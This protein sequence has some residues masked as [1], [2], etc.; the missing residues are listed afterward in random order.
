MHPGLLGGAIGLLASAALAG[1][2]MPGAPRPAS[3][4][5]AATPGLDRELRR[6]LGQHGFT[7]L[8]GFTV[9]ARLGRPLDARLADLGRL[10]FFDSI[11][12]LRNDTSCASCHGPAWGFGDSQSIAIG[13]GNNGISGPDRFGA[14][15]QRRA[16][17]VIN[18]AFYP[19]QMLN[20]RFESLSG[21]SFDNSMGFRFPPPE[22][23]VAFPP[24]DPLVRTLTAAQAHLPPTDLVEMA[25]FTGTAGTI[26]PE[27][28]QFDDGLGQPVPPP[29][30]SGFRNAPIRAAVVARLNANARYRRLFRNALSL[31]RGRPIDF[32]MIARALAEFQ[33][34]LTLMDAPI[35]RFAR[36]LNVG[37][38]TAQKRGALLFFGRARCVECHAVAGESNE[39]F[40][41]FRNHVLAVPQ[42]APVFGA[43]VLLPLP[44]NKGNVKFDGPGFDEDFG[45]EQVTG[46]P[47]DRYAF[48]TS[49]L[50]N[51][52]VQPHFFHNGTLSAIEDAIRHHLDVVAS[53]TGYDPG[54]GGGRRRPAA[55]TGS[56]PAD[57]GAVGPHPRHAHRADARRVPGPAGV[58]AR[59]P[60]RP[61]RA[62]PQPLPPDAHFGAQ[63]QAG[64]HLPGLPALGTPARIKEPRRLHVK[65][66]V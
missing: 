30:A 10:I 62:A 51:A 44:Q 15:N 46:D 18:S 1:A 43:P 5:E 64:R 57:A 31:P 35:D 54:G 16:P 56:D 33:I 22:G 6:I 9:E 63:R 45:A 23:T 50:R 41:D 7:G 13:V 55:A 39:M 8:V 61:A 65:G 32:P 14:R 21:D 17:S 34:S 48:R 19:R 28:D 27:Y 38:T 60:P 58:R 2:T 59:R 20:G 11:L 4:D 25:G 53:A 26:G 49:P 29:D 47:A 36:G 37:M 3:V 52:A 40:T 66:I 24:N 42:I 12:S